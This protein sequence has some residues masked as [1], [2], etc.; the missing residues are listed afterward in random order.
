MDHE[1]QSKLLRVT[2]MLTIFIVLVVA[3]VQAYVKFAKLCTLNIYSLMCS[4]H[5]SKKTF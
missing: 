5:T 2:S 3:L 4:N 1:K